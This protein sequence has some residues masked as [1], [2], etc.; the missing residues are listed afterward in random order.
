MPGTGGVE[1]VEELGR[2]GAWWPVIV[3]TGHADVPLAIQAMKAGGADF[4]EKP[5]DDETMLSAIRSA[6]TTRRRRAG[7]SRAA[8]GA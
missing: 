3:I 8:A 7:A 5:F 6:G 4:I 1:L 2:C